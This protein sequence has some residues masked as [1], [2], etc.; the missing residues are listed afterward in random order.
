MNLFFDSVDLYNFVINE[1]QPT[2]EGQENGKKGGFTKTPHFKNFIME[3]G[4]FEMGF[5]VVS[6]PRQSHT[7][8]PI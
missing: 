5:T 7:K 6:G 3:M 4:V 1:F 2:C 8:R